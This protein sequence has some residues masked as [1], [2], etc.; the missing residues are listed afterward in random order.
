M[1]QNSHF[2]S[3]KN[4]YI[5]FP[6]I[7][8]ILLWLTALLCSFDAR[9]SWYIFSTIVM[10]Y[11]PIN[12]KSSFW[13]SLIFLHF[14]MLIYNN[15]YLH[16]HLVLFHLWIP[17]ISVEEDELKD[18]KVVHKLAVI[19]ILA[20]PLLLPTLSMMAVLWLAKS[21]DGSHLL[22]VIQLILSQS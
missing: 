12:A 17:L 19:W 4:W 11:S 7:V 10:Y 2:D 20:F 18:R 21:H 1:G 16:A 14:W 5:L 15:K 6:Y 9:Y 22:R 13:S 3:T 8:L